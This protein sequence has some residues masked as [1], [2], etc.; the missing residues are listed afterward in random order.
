[1]AEQVR[2]GIIG[3][4]W[5]GEQHIKGYAGASGCKVVAIA[6]LI[7]A[8]RE[9]LLGWAPNARQY[10][11][12]EELLADKDVEAVSVCLPNYLHAPVT[13]AA[14]KAGKHVL[15]EKP[16]AMSAAE[17]KKM[18]AAANKAGKV[19]T[20]GVQRRFGGAEQ[21]AKQAID[22][23]YAGEVYHARASWMRTRGIPIGT[24]WFIEKSKAGGGALI[25]IGVHLL[26]LAWYL[27]GQPK[28]IS[29]YG[30]TH[31]RF[32]HTLGNGKL[33]DVDDAAFAMIK[34]EGGK[35][36]ELA[37]S[38]AINQAPTQQGTICLL[39]GEKAAIEVYTPEGAMLY[40]NFDPQGDAKA[41]PLKPPKVVYHPALTRHFR[42]CVLGR[43]KPLIGPHEGVQIMQM[44]DAIYKS[45]E[46]GRSVEIRG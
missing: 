28:P 11:T 36:L 19:L 3:G 29:A 22:K 8:R 45:G 13:M 31:S 5:P 38:W 42:D 34:F 35:S 2:V 46:T 9:K 26:D 14:L 21:A 4:G 7:P 17:A 33:I 43:C 25:D 18:E 15:C 24:G 16:P 6:D 39:Y 27:L 1:M 12:A 32:A 40:R 37:A 30:V 20:F 44:L 41:H 23:G 10:A